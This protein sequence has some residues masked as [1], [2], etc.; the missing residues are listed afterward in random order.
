M[1]SASAIWIQVLE[2]EGERQRTTF[3]PLLERL[4]VN[5]LHDQV[6]NV[7][8][9][10]DVVER[11]DVRMVQA[12][13][14][15]GF[16]LEA[17]PTGR[18]GREVFGKRLDGYGAVQARIDGAI[19]LAHAAGG[20]EGLDL[21]GAKGGPGKTAM[22]GPLLEP[23]TNAVGSRQ[24]RAMCP[25]CRGFNETRGSRQMRQQRFDLA[26]Q[27]D[28]A[29]AGGSEKGR[30]LVGVTLPGRVIQALDLLPSFWRHLLLFQFTQ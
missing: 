17:F 29:S 9:I 1:S 13:D 4:S 21:V 22:K 23:A 3:Q 11:A 12:G 20:D 7:I 27:C 6:V 18:I 15:L 30:A 24:Q 16:A 19:H 28:V 14:D 8:V 10:A 2:R 5:V 26:A 25:C